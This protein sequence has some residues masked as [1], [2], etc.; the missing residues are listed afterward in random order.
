VGAGHLWAAA[1]G[2]TGLTL[3]LSGRRA[4][5]PGRGEFRHSLRLR[6]VG[7]NPAPLGSLLPTAVVL[8]EFAD[9]RRRREMPVGCLYPEVRDLIG[10]QH[11]AEGAKR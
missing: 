5:R 9:Q 1:G 4:T 11:G 10:G 7:L 2:P 3:P 8:D 6:S